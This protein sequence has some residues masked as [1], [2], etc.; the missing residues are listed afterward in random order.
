MR[1]R[2]MCGVRRLRLLRKCNPVSWQRQRMCKVVESRVTLRYGSEEP[3][4]ETSYYPLS[5]E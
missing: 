3:D 5:H 4:A 2:W 1:V